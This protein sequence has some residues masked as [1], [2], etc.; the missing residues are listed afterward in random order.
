MGTDAEADWVAVPC[1]SECNTALGDRGG[2]TVVGRARYME[3][4]IREKY[5]AELSMP[6]WPQCEIE[7]MG[8]CLRS[9]IENAAIVRGWVLRRLDFIRAVYGLEAV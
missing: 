2:E 5:K 1:C 4:W 3:R 9:S 7:E 6:D 8:R